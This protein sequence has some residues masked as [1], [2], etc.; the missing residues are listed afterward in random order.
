VNNIDKRELVNENIPNGDV[1]II[2][3]SGARL[4]VF[5]KQA[6]LVMASNKGLDIV[7]V[8]SDARPMIGKLMNHSKFKFDQQKKQK[9]IKKNQKVTDLKEVQLSPVIQENDINVKVKNA[10]KFIEAGHKVKVTLRFKG[11]MITHTDIG[12]TVFNKFVEKMSDVAEI[13]GKPKLEG[14]ILIGY[15]IKKK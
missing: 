12:Q 7:I 10:K 1:M 15:L 11:R 9:E 2:D 3:E 6:A 13:E 14:N 5:S 8:S 4:G